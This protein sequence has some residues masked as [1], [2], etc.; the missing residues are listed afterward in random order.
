M[1]VNYK[2]RGEFYRGAVVDVQDD[3]DTLHIAYEEGDEQEEVALRLIQPELALVENGYVEHKQKA[4]HVK[5]RRVK[6][7]GW[8]DIE[9]PDGSIEQDVRPKAFAKIVAA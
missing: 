8:I 9:Y 1:W 2:G 4:I 6:P 3:D 5:V 7:N